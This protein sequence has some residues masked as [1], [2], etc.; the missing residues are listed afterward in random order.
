MIN[1]RYSVKKKIGQGRSAVYL[2]E[3][4]EQAGKK[5][6]I[7]FLPANSSP[8]EHQIFK[9][10]FQTIQKLDHPN[11]IQAYER[12]T[13]VEVTENESIFVGS[14]YLV[15]EYFDGKGLLSYPIEDE[16]TLKSIITQ[17]SSVLFYLHQSRYIYYDLKPEN[18]LVSED[19]GQPFVKVIDLG[20]AKQSTGK[21]YEN[22]TG[23]AEYIAPELL[24]K[25]SHDHRVDL[26]SLGILLYRLIYQKFPFD[27]KDQMEIYK[28]HIEKDFTF[29]D[30]KYSD[31]VIAVVKKLLRK[32][33]EDRYFTSIQILYDLGIPIDENIYRDWIPV[34]VFSDRRDVLNIV[35]RYV[36]MPSSGEIIIIKGFEKSGKTAV[37]QE[38]YARYENLILINNDRSKTGLQFIKHFLNQL[39]FNE[40]VFHKLSEDT[41]E[42][43][44]KIFNNQAENLIEDLKLIVTKV[45]QYAKLIILLDDFNLYD[46]FTIEVF[47]EIFPIFQVNGCNIILTEKSDLDYV[48]DFISNSLILNLSSFTEAQTDELLEKTFADFFPLKEVRHLLMLYADLLPGNIIEFLRDLVI[49]RIIQFEYDGIKVFSDENTEKILANLYE[50]IY[51][52]RYESLNEDEIKIAS[53]LSAFEIIPERDVLIHLTGFSDSVFEKSI[54]NL[55]H[56][57][58]LQSQS[59]TGLNFVSDGIKNYIY[60]QV[61]NK[62][63]FHEKIASAIHENFPNFSKIELARQYQVC[64][65]YDESYTLLM[66]EA[67][68][69]EKIFALKYERNILEILLKLPLSTS[70]TN[71]IKFRLCSL[72][73]DLN[74]FKNSYEF[75]NELLNKKLDKED[76]KY[77]LTI[78]GDSLIRLG[79]VEKGKEILNSLLPSIEDGDRKIRVMLDIAGAELD[80]N[81]FDSASKIC[82][83]VLGNSLATHE[84]R[85]DA[86]NLLGLINIRQD[87]EL[88]TALSNFKNC[89]IEY[90]KAKTPQRIAAIEI[91]IGNIYNMKGEYELVEKHWKKSLEISSSIGNLSHQGSILTNFG[92]FYF[93][94]LNFDLAI[95]NYTKAGIIF[96]SLGDL[97]NLGLS[98]SNLGELYVFTC[99][100]QKGVEYLESARENFDKIQ[101]VIEAS[102][103]LFLLGKLYFK[104]GDDNKLYEIIAD[105][106]KINEINETPIKL[107]LNL[108]LLKS[109]RQIAMKKE[110]NVEDVKKVANDYM[111]QE[112]KINYFDS[113]T[114]LV[115]YFLSREETVNAYELLFSKDFTEICNSNIYLNAEKLYLTG[116]IA[117]KNSKLDLENPIYYFQEALNLINDLNVTE[118]TWKVL[119]EISK[120]YFERGNI[121]KA[122]EFASYGLSLIKLFGDSFIDQRLKGIY[123]DDPVRKNAWNKLIEI[124]NFE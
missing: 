53:V 24:K 86:Y 33:P 108:N 4:V 1:R 71:E 35:N 116:I 104:I 106:A 34:R 31:E 13:V 20:F 121:I 28:A 91:N 52:I 32:K 66:T 16:F 47:R 94:K 41:S 63:K 39:I 111:V 96:N 89:L 122:K 60:L 21:E 56:K 73:Y 83:L 93:Y 88:N 78:R 118:L 117:S 76:K 103:A 101:N 69:A 87:Y 114:L 97:Y 51:S 82:N 5:Y 70:Y 80:L 15:M 14:K 115:N 107:D 50:E 75:A 120:N 119:F 29:P 105:L 59:P 109:L 10:E 36:T 2:C 113:I 7:K 55:Q 8:E 81:N 40:L 90:E 100:Y 45:T 65:K 124:I 43:I 37:S 9:E 38:I 61:P 99:E 74:I 18:I 48:T 110:I 95:E 11:I 62:R 19:N 42:R 46:S 54:E 98:E 26:Y 3:D 92:V 58:V 25:E 44:I 112:E 68:E 85:G 12:G 84:K 30:T 64:E 57:H 23:T 67:K 22:I 6:A 79:E 27:S 102:E 77:L 72:Y 123:L 49:L 17:I